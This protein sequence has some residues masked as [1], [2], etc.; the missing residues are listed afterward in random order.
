MFAIVSLAFAT[1]G[2]AVAGTIVPVNLTTSPVGVATCTSCITPPIT[3]TTTGT[4]ENQLFSAIYPS[5]PLTPSSSPQP[6]GPTSFIVAQQPAS[7][8]DDTYV[9]TNSANLDTSILVDLGTCTGTSPASACGLYN[10]DDLYTM[11]Q[12]TGLFGIQGVTVT[13][14]GVLADG[15]T[16][17]EDV[18]DLTSGVDYRGTNSSQATTCTDANSNNPTNNGT[19][20]VGAS[21]D[22]ASVSGTDP[23]PGGTGGNA[24]ATFNNVFGPQSANGRNY[25][26]DVQELELGTNFLGSYLDSI[27]FT[28]DAPSTKSQIVFTGLTGDEASTSATPE[29]GTVA[30]LGIGFALIAFLKMRVRSSNPA[31]SLN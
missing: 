11:I 4:F 20:C 23:N 7:P 27:V 24:V 26:I 31:T 1:L 28:N 3:S 9:S 14:N 29:P 13:L 17:I 25:Y 2:G 8:N 16:P 5:N 21:S 22:T 10:V 19:A 12:A 18:I 15:V 6:I 30:L